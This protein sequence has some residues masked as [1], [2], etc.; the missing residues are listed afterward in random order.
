VAVAAVVLELAFVWNIRLLI[1]G[2]GIFVE[3]A[4]LTRA[5]VAA[6]ISP[7]RPSDADLD[8]SLI[9]VPSPHSLERIV[10][11]DGS[12]VADWFWGSQVEP[13]RPAL[14][15]EANRRLVEGPPIYPDEAP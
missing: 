6:A 12:P 2:R 7:D 14:L 3:R 13:L 9:L 10:A 15:E 8:R 5:L 4:A 1:D 11:E